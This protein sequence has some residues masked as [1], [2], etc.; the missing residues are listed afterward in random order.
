MRELSAEY[1][2]VFKLFDRMEELPPG[3]EKAKIKDICDKIKASL[4]KISTLWEVSEKN[5]AIQR[6]YSYID[7]QYSKLNKGD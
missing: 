6:H 7:Y 5:S 1:E 4:D 3:D 2:K